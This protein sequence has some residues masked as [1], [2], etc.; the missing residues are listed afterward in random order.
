MCIQTVVGYA[1]QPLLKG[2]RILDDVLW[3]LP[4]ATSLPTSYMSEIAE[5]N[6]T[7]ILPLMCVFG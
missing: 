6:A 4:V 7:V 2:E 1:F 5:E 3:R